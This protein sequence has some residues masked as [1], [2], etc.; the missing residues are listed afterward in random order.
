LQLFEVG[1]LNRGQATVDVLELPQGP[2]CGG[3]GVALILG[4]KGVEQVLGVQVRQVA[5][6]AIEDSA[7]FVGL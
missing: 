5:L 1:Q 3:R 2:R 6:L 4:V 7:L